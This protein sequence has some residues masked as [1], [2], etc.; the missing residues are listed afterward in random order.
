MDVT[1]LP[2]IYI[3]V[4]SL[5]CRQGFRAIPTSQAI[6]LSGAQPL[7]SA[8]NV[9]PPR[10]RTLYACEGSSLEIVCEEGTHINLIRANFGRFSIS[11][12]NDNGNVDWSVDCMSHRSFRVMQESCGMKRSCKLPASANVFGDPCLGTL[13][14]LEAHYQCMPDYPQLPYST[15]RPNYSFK[16]PLIPSYESSDR[17]YGENTGSSPNPRIIFPESY[18]P[19][20][21]IPFPAIEMDSKEGSDVSE[22]E[23]ASK[24]STETSDGYP[25]LNENDIPP[26]VNPPIISDNETPVINSDDDKTVNEK[27][28]DDNNARQYYSSTPEPKW[29]SS[30]SEI[31]SINTNKHNNNNNNNNEN[32]ESNGNSN[33][34]NII[35]H[36]N[37]ER[38][39]DLSLDHCQPMYSRGL[40]WNWT[41][42]GHA[43]NQS[44]PAG[45]KGLVRWSCVYSNGNPHWTPLMADMS[46]CSS[47]WVQHLESRVNSN[48]ESV[49]SLT[50]ELAKSCKEKTLF[51]A[52][53]FRVTDILSQLVI[54]TENAIIET[55][56]ENQRHHV[57]REMLNSVQDIVSSLLD[58]NQMESWNELSLSYQK[59][60]INLMLNSLERMGLLMADTKQQ[61]SDYLRAHQNIFVSVHIRSIGSLSY[62]LHLP[63]IV[64]TSDEMPNSV[65]LHSNSVYLTPQTLTEYS[66]ASGLVKVVFLMYKKLA[67]LM[68]PELENADHYP[69]M[70]TPDGGLA[71]LNTSRIINSEI[72]GILLNR[73][74]YTPLSEPIEFTLKHL[75]T[76][77]VTNAKCV[78]WDIDRRDW[79]DQGCHTVRTNR[80]HT[81]CKC[82]HLTNFAILMDVNHVQISSGNELALRV[83]TVIGCTVSIICLTIT[84]ITL[85]SFRSL[86]SVRTT[87]H[88]NLCLCLI[89]AELIFLLGINETKIKLICGL[90]A[91]GL[92][93]FFLAAFLWM[94][95]EGFQ[96]YVMLVEVFD[97]EKSRVNWYYLLSYGVPA[98]LVIISAIIDPL[99]YGTPNY[100]WLRSDNYF[101]WAFV[102]PVIAILIANIIFL[103]IAMTT[104]CRHIPHITSNKT[105]EQTKLTNIKLW[106][107]G[108]LALVF[109]LGITWSFGL[110]YLSR[111]SLFMAYLFT[112]TNSMQGLFIFVFNCLT[113][114]K[115]RTEYRKLFAALNLK[116]ICLDS[117]PSKSI[118]TTREQMPSSSLSPQDHRTSLYVNNSSAASHP[119]DSSII[120]VFPVQN[121]VHCEPMIGTS[122]LPTNGLNMNA[123]MAATGAESPKQLRRLTHKYYL[124]DDSSDYGCKRL[125][126]SRCPKQSCRDIYSLHSTHLASHSPN[127]IE[128]I[129]ECI[130]EDPYV[131]K[132][133]L[134]AIQRS[135]DGQHVRTLSDSSRHSDNRP[136]ISCSTSSPRSHN[137]HIQTQ[138][139][140]NHLPAIVK[141]NTMNKTTIICTNH[142]SS[143]S[144]PTVA[145]L[146]GN[147][148]VICCTLN[149]HQL[150]DHN[151]QTIQTHLR[152]QYLVSNGLNNLNNCLPS[153]SR[154][155]S[156]D[157]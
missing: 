57:V 76:E 39:V 131:A 20:Q 59:T 123:L 150:C 100:C 66:S 96:L 104:M 38:A 11:V 27:N 138:N 23:S 12:C 113:N 116:P 110:L 34:D 85:V 81:S 13:K 69:V 74:R 77:N 122:G 48:A 137:F 40:S 6:Y 89:I 51:S 47:L 118:D 46:D 154:H 4:Q 94:F 1:V 103:S 16:N 70:M 142:L 109:L 45:A 49:V 126:Q 60:A 157:C 10:Y 61:T 125:Q 153:K 82:N 30:G 83:I 65:T 29:I 108:S 25:R 106:I 36:E 90:I 151:N 84:F 120:N 78:F 19:S 102:G 101:I 155:L 149:D 62:G 133:L 8:V 141:D 88:T 145:V 139:T 112:I 87:I 80:T 121:G 111:E 140:G 68:K 71:P 5:W 17:N 26:P 33:S 24:K 130:D 129:Y 107:R 97:H 95:F 124:T 7:A 41:L 28:N 15:P 99:S 52:D 64:D 105:K 114:E 91:C 14:Y 44:C 127:F 53:L 98:I 143:S 146:N 93:Y 22:T 42:V 119:K 156:S 31:D 128:H 54:R 79:S 63:P 35:M 21:I 72:I 147:N 9:R 50:D 73:E 58:D 144:Q 86:R 148:Q 152:Q 55:Y 2:L 136:L 92:H 43:A 115:V 56:D 75:I 67:H 37:I 117:T 3:S 132:L 32:S 134:P 18:N 135:L